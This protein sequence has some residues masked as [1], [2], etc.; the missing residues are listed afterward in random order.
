MTFAYI[1]ILG[2]WLNR[3]TQLPEEIGRLSSLKEVYL[4]NNRFKAFPKALI[5]MKTL[6]YVDFQDNTICS[7]NAEFAAW[8]KKW[9]DQW[10]SKQKC[11]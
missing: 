11:W 3:F 7:P 10:K 9:D 1:A 4:S 6:T 8:L 5:K 2:R